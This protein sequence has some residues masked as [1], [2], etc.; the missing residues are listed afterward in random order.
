MIKYYPGSA[1][2]TATLYNSKIRGSFTGHEKTQYLQNTCA[3]RMS[4]ALLRS[5]FQLPRTKD[6][7]ASMLG[8]DKKWYWLRVANLRAELSARFGGFDTELHLDMID[9]R[10]ADDGFAIMPFYLARK[11]KAEEFLRTRL[12]GR[13]GIIAFVVDGWGTDATGHLTLWDGTAQ[14]LAFAPLHDDPESKTYYPWLTEVRLNE[15][16]NAKYLVQ[17]KQVQFWELK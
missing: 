4:Y 6:R 17:V 1:E 11:A 3:I 9:A 7:E 8:A 14:T 15:D 5:G 13:N 12:A 10:L 2:T 16:T